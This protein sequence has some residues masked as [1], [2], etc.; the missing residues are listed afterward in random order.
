MLLPLIILN[1]LGYV[2]M[3]NKTRKLFND[4]IEKLKGKIVSELQGAAEGKKDEVKKTLNKKLNAGLNES[5]KILQE[6]ETYMNKKLN[7][8][9]KF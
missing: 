4:Q 5:R 9:E 7:E 3:T 1:E 2:S 8:K 6:G